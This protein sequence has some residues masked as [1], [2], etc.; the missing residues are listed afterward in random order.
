MN[1]QKLKMN[2]KLTPLSIALLSLGGMAQAQLAGAPAPDAGAVIQQVRPAL[3][4]PTESKFQIEFN[5]DATR[6]VAPGGPVAELKQLKIAGNRIYSEAEI[7]AALGSVTGKAYDLAGFRQISNQVS[8]FYRTRGY[9]FARAFIPPQD[10]KDGTLTIE[11][12][13]GTYASISTDAKDASLQAFLQPYLATL[14]PGEPIAAAPLERAVLI[15]NDIPGVKAVPVIRPGDQTGTG[16][17][18]VLV[19]EEKASSGE[20]SVDNL[21]SRY[22]GYNRLNLGY[23]TNRLFTLGDEFDFRGMATDEQMFFGRMAYSGALMANGLRGSV[24][25]SRTQYELGKDFSALQAV[26]VANQYSLGLS[27]PLL[28]SQLANVNLSASWLRKELKDDFRSTGT[29]LEKSSQSV[30]LVLGFDRRDGFLSGGLFYGAATLTSGK[31]SNPND[32]ANT[33]GR[34]TK[35]NL[36]LV[37]LQFLTSQLSVFLKYSAQD[38][39]KNLDSS[40]DFFLGGSQGVRAYPQGEASGDKGYLGTAEVRYQWGAFAPYVFYDMG[41]VHAYSRPTDTLIQEKRKLSGSGLGVRYAQDGWQFGLA[42]A[43][44]STGGKPTSDRFEDPKPRLMLT[45][46]KSF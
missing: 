41:Q 14:K 37:R 15:M 22:T 19:K 7:V 27:Y 34:F 13:E 24:S 6:E 38:A 30:P 25:L 18:Q 28:R 31:M 11:V 44:R 9:P 2:K 26:G 42:A 12:L 21:G 10:M 20:V 8:Q 23:K 5:G 4:A 45:A 16:N 36:D 33:T 29:V 39:N 35:T 43:W 3:Q 46:G 40:E 1:H 17:L 32:F